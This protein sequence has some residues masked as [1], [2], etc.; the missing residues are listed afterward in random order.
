MKLFTVHFRMLGREAEIVLVK[1]GF[2]WPAFFLSAVWALWNRLW[3]VAA[4]LVLIEVSIDLMLQSFH[5]GHDIRAAITVALALL[6]G[7]FA[8]DLRRFSLNKWGGFREVGVVAGDR[9]D[10]AEYRFLSKRPDVL[11]ELG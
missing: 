1:E 8:N 7:V 2:C 6:V 9:V 5:A 4:G 11:L 10:D 3:I